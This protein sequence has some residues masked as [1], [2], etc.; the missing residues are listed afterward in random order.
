RGRE[1]GSSAGSSNARTYDTGVGGRCLGCGGRLR[2]R[3]RGLRWRGESLALPAWIGNYNGIGGVIDDNR[4]VDVVVD[5]I[6]WRRRNVVWRVD[7]DGHRSI[8]RDWKNVGINRRR[9]RSQIDEVDRPRRQEKYRWR[10]RG[11]KSKIRIVENQYRTFDVNDLFRRRRRHVIADDFESRRRVESTRPTCNAAPVGKQR[12]NMQ[13]DAAH[14]RHGSR[15]GNDA[16]TTSK[17][18]A[19]QRSGCA[20]TSRPRAGLQQLLAPVVPSDHGDRRRGS[21]HSPAG[22]RD[23]EL[24]DRLPGHQN[25]GSASIES[26]K[27]VQAKPEAAAHPAPAQKSKTAPA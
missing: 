4:V 14:R 12:T 25:H 17:R 21:L 11:L 1:Q 9:W 7:I 20:A 22:C 6:V 10:R 27:S 19:Y 8:G 15:A 13:A 3:C 26:M 18:E 5:D 23:R 2:L 24:R 16:N